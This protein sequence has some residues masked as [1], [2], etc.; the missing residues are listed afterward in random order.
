MDF[1]ILAALFVTSVSFIA[2]VSA[3]VQEDGNSVAALNSNINEKF[4]EL[5]ERLDR[6]E[7]KVNK[8][9]DKEDSQNGNIDSEGLGGSTTA[10]PLSASHESQAQTVQDEVKRLKK[11]LSLRELLSVLSILSPLSKMS[12]LT[13]YSV[14]LRDNVE[15]IITAP[16]IIIFQL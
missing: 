7:I 16:F 6:L 12:M 5:F 1:R 3:S 8:I 10:K 14:S 11:I 2:Q 9:A 15:S 13:I 4:Q